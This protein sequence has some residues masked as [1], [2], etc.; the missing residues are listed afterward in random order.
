[1]GSERIDPLFFGPPE[2]RLFGCHHAPLDGANAKLGVVIAAPL[3][4]EYSRSHRALRQL[5]GLVATNGM[6]ALRFFVAADR[7]H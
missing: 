4:H 6:R 2:R 5:A 7:I 1:M 3:G